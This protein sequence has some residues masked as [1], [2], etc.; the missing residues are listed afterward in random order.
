MLTVGFLD[1]SEGG[2]DFQD[3]YEQT[4]PAESVEELRVLKEILGNGECHMVGQRGGC[5]RRGLFRQILR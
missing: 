5:D 1:G 3:F 4:P 2:E